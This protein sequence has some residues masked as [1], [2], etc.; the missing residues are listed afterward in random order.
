MTQSQPKRIQQKQQVRSQAIDVLVRE[1]ADLKIRV[2]QLVED[3]PRQKP[4]LI[5]LPHIQ[6][7][8]P[9]NILDNELKQ[10][11]TPAL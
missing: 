8:I 6:I 10:I 9:L 1:L 5:G 7:P 3:S 11:S 4:S 2:K